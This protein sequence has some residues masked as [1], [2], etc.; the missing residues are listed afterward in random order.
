[1]TDTDRAYEALGKTRS[2]LARYKQ[3]NA[4]QQRRIREL[5]KVLRGMLD[6]Y[7]TCRCGC[8]PDNYW[9]KSVAILKGKE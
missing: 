1:M 2:E 9:E 6:A 4:E 5:E 7:N 8:D 3:Q